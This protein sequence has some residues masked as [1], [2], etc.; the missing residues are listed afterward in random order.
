M[1]AVDHCGSKG[2][3]KKTQRNEKNGNG[4]L[5]CGCL[6]GDVGVL[7]EEKMLEEKKE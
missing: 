3:E 6:G 4:S 5:L 1:G 2:E 7:E